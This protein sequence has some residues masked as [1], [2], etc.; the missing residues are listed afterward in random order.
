[1]L[2]L[3]G[4]R[5]AT[6]TYHTYFDESVQGLELGAPVKYRGVRIGSIESIEVAPDRKRVAVGLMLLQKEAAR[7]G[8]AES[9]PELRT[10]LATQ[11]VTGVKFVEIDFFDPATNPV[12]RLSFPPAPRYIPARASMM[13]GLLDNLEAVGQKLPELVDRAVAGLGKLEAVLDDFHGQRVAHQIADAVAGITGATGDLRRLLQHLD[14]AQIGDRA[15]GLLANLDTAVTR[16]NS[17]LGRIDGDAGLV[18]SARRAADSIG[19]VSAGAVGSAAE[20]ERTLR[21]LGEAAQAFRE[22]VEAI[23]RDPDM[24]VKGRGRSSRP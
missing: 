9:S 10:Q 13:K 14:R 24:L 4:T 20:L 1:A 15:A 18:A 17:V 3:Y 8:L 7:L 11:G 19:D 5:S 21:E 16:L 23:D 2:G 12:P 22:L 6:V